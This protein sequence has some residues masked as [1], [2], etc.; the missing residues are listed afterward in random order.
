MK[1]N[2]FLHSL[3]P[4]AYEHLSPHLHKQRV[5]AGATLV[6]QGDPVGAVYFP[7]DVQVAASLNLGDDDDA[8]VSVPGLATSVGVADALARLP[9]RC[10]HLART[11]GVVMRVSASDLRQAAA[12]NIDLQTA[13]FSAIAVEQAQAAI[14][15]AC[16]LRHSAAQR[17]ASHLLV[18]A[19]ITG[20]NT[21]HATQ[22]ELGEALHL[23][24]TTVNAAMMTLKRAGAVRSRRGLIDLQ[25]LEGLRMQACSC[26]R[27]ILMADPHRVVGT[28]LELVFEDQHLLE[29]M[30]GPTLAV[31]IEEYGFSIA[32]R[33]EAARET[34]Q[35]LTRELVQASGTDFVALPRLSKA[36]SYES[37]HI[38]PLND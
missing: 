37:V 33:S 18:Q 9:S 10:T 4:S 28:L 17:V 12:S 11:S 21:V 32:P 8:P 16:Q 22:E 24:R 27:S 2:L 1:Q 5:E 36:A 3:S 20:R 30:R 14:L 25:H 6:R 23:Q 35:K 13:L 26:H 38:L 7:T 29:L 34:F 15:V 19:G 31:Q